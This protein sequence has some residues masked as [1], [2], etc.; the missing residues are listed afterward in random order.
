[1]E[2]VQT[3]RVSEAIPSFSEFFQEHRLRFVRACI[4]LEGSVPGGEDL[5]QEAMARILERWGRVSG[6]DDP[7]G[8]LYRTALNLHRNAVRRASSS[9]RLRVSAPVPDPDVTDRRLD[10]VRGIRTLPVT[11]REALFLVE[12]LGYSAEDAARLLGVKGESIR[13]RLHRARQT[14]RERYGDDDE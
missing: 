13:G 5:A 9:L 14:L 6:L 3:A 7:E 12:W 8:Y 1:M 2:A 10:I 11:Q 4:V